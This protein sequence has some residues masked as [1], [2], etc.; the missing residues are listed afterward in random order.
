MIVA[1]LKF[2]RELHLGTVYF[3]PCIFGMGGWMDGWEEYG[4]YDFLGH[5]ILLGY[6]P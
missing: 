5:G 6:G 3:G 4:A 2:C 1:I